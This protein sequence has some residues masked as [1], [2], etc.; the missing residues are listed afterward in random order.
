MHVSVHHI[1]TDPKKWEQVTQNMMAAIEQGRLPQGLKA[2]MYL[3]GTDA[4]KADCLWEAQS[5][6]TLRNFLD[7]EIGTAARNDYF[8][9]NTATAFGLSGQEELRKAA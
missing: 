4:R 5:L 1:I 8:Q 6:D 3:P 2:L 7:R 9:I